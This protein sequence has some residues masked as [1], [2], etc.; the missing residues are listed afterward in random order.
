MPL[1]FED[2]SNNLMRIKMREK[3]AVKGLPF[4]AEG[5]PFLLKVFMEPPYETATTE[6]KTF[7]SKHQIPEWCLDTH[8]ADRRGADGVSRVH[9]DLY[10]DALYDA[11]G[12][13]LWPEARIT[14]EG[15]LWK[16]AEQ[17]FPRGEGGRVISLK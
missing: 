10:G 17:V 16:N 5:F 6:L 9:L 14:T 2:W 11:E 12:Q 1:R 15:H 8:G 13:L 7:M 3:Y 4:P